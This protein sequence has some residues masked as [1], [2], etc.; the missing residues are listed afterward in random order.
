MSEWISVKI[1][2]PKHGE[3]VLVYIPHEKMNRLW[4]R[5]DLHAKKY[6]MKIKY[7]FKSAD[8]LDKKSRFYGVTHWMSLPHSPIESPT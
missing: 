6:C 7:A 1:K 4:W 2:L 8:P 5:E 3:W